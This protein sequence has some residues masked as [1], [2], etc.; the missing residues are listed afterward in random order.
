MRS[1]SQ[2]SKSFEQRRTEFMQNLYNKYQTAKPSN[3]RR[4]QTVRQQTSTSRV[5]YTSNEN[6]LVRYD[7]SRRPVTTRTEIAKPREIK[8]IF[9][10]FSPLQND[11][12]PFFNKQILSS[13]IIPSES[14][15]QKNL[16]YLVNT[17]NIIKIKSLFH[18]GSGFMKSNTISR[19]S[20]KNND[21][22]FTAAETE[23]VCSFRNEAT[24]SRVKLKFKRVVKLIVVFIK[25]VS[26]HKG[27][28]QKIESLKMGVDLVVTNN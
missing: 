4:A 11:S 1:D 26:I 7:P 22:T 3:L 24:A 2:N 5:S 18:S 9:S 8:K 23:T 14:Y 6:Q 15:I 19:L 20:E 13:A 17:K 12:D 21:D 28:R 10:T 27:S 25:F 16:K